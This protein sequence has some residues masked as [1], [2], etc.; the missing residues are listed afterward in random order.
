MILKSFPSE[1]V[2]ED[3]R[4]NQMIQLTRQVL[5]ASLAIEKDPKVLKTLTIALVLNQ[6]SDDDPKKPGSQ[7]MIGDVRELDL[8]GAKAIDAYW[9]R[10]NF[11][12]SD[13]YK[14]NLR[15]ASFRGSVLRGTQ[16][17]EAILRDAV[18]VD[19]DCDGANFKLSD[20]RKADLT[21]AILTKA[22]FEDARVFGCVMTGATLGN[23]PDVWVDVSE[24]GDD[25]NRIKLGDWLAA[26]PGTKNGASL[27]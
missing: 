6:Y 27:T 26:Q 22:R 9:A 3:A 10:V 5:A 15:G 17:R 1:W 24:A 18:F 19:A 7:R 21:N 14:A 20:L 16:F 23:N 8:S 13:F 2:V 4:R 12:Y 11:S 25:S